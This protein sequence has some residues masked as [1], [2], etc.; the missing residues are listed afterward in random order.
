MLSIQKTNGFTLLEVVVSVAVLTMIVGISVVG[1]RNM[2]AFQQ[3]NHAL[4]DVEFIMKQTQLSARS[5]VKDANHGVKFTNDSIIQFVGDT[6]SPTDSN[7]KTTSYELVTLQTDFTGGADE[8]IFRKLTGL[9]SATGT[10]E[11]QGVQFNASDTLTLTET[12]G[13][14]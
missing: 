6:Y 13:I 3:Y 5:A 11:V 1:F 9:P 7:N 4:S 8:I 12:G 2:A 14:Q 10:I